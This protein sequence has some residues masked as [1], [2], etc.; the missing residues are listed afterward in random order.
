MVE[1][2]RTVPELIAL[3]ADNVTGDI[4]PQDSRDF[5]VSA[6][7]VYGG[8]ALINGVTAQ[9][10]LDTTPVQLTGF[11]ADTVA[12]GVIPDQA[13][14]QIEVDID[15]VYLGLFQ[16]SFSGSNN[17]TFTFEFYIDGV[18]S[19]FAQD[20][21]LNASGDIGG[22][23]MFALATLTKA[24]IITIFVNADGAAKTLTAA[25]MQLLLVRVG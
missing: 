20:R 18:A 24:E 23:S 15:G 9:A 13:N 16:I 8:I 7:G 11:T 3:F 5:I 12:S 6:L 4:S 1:T 14:D 10:G 17:T 19:N 2:I 22:A 25:D 21:R